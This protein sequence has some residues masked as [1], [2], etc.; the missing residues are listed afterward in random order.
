MCREMGK[1]YMRD[2]KGCASGVQV[3]RWV[4]SVKG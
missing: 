2:R 3:G 1:F 4:D